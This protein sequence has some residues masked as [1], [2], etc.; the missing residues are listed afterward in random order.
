MAYMRSAKLVFLLFALASLAWAAVPQFSGQKR[1]GLTT[2][3]QWE[4]AVAADGS[5]RIYILYPHYG[6]VPDCKSCRVP[7]MLLV[8]SNDNGKSWQTPQA[9]L[10]SNSGQFD[11]QI[12]ID[13]R[14]GAPFTRRGC[15]TLSAWSFLRS[16]WTSA[17][18]GILRLRFAA[19]WN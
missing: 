6:N 3:D 14:T 10:E 8:A 7:S 5:G 19:K 11:P 4:P 16:Q 15:R 9:I 12:A 18:R 1:V 13:Q 2:G 17:P